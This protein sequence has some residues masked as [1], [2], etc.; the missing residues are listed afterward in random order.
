MNDFFAPLEYAFMRD[1]L[2]VGIVISAMSAV[3]SC[4]LVLKGWSLMGDAVSHAVL[5]GIVL[6]YIAGIPLA[7]GA[8]AAG[9][10]CAVGTGFIRHH[11][12]IKEDTVMGVVFTG[13]F[14]FG[15]V[16]FSRTPS[17]MHLDHI[18]LGNI[19][20][21][22]RAQLWQTLL[23]GSTVIAITLAFRRDLLLICFDPA[24]ARVIGLR[25]GLLNHLLLALLALAIVVSIQAVGIILVVAMLVT[26][27]CIAHL[28]ADRFDRMLAIA[29]LSAVSS[30]IAGVFISYHIDGSTAAC[31]VL[32]QALLFT[33]SLFFAPKHGIMA[34]GGRAPV[35]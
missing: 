12:R 13:M 3:L 7:I 4:Y 20:G 16:L 33:I 14:A 2:V 17:D 29:V 11:S 21:V 26:P 28:W 9:L 19:L 8:F 22:T 30:T 10:F 18:L 31:I 25:P 32:T 1:A 6:A 15:L 23:L 24:H 34:W 5:P 35:A 27:G